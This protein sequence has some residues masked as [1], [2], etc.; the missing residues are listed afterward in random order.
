MSTVFA[1][2]PAPFAA[3]S[4]EEKSEQQQLSPS[5]SSLLSPSSLV[6]ELHLFPVPSAAKS[7]EV[8]DAFFT[9]PDSGILWDMDGT[10]VESKQIW[11][12]LCN[13][14]AVELGYGPLEYEQWEPTFGQS[15]DGQSCA[16][17]ATA[18]ARAYSAVQC[19]VCMHVLSC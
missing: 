4:M 14:A 17:A 2:R 11:W 15:V 9:A 8:P 1:R 16:H 19:V 7:S 12:H 18:H 13:A 3:A 6:S 10:L 5:M